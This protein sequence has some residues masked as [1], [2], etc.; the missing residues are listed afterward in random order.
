M[1]NTT[2]PSLSP[3][4]ARVLDRAFRHPRRS[5][6]THNGDALWELATAGLVNGDALSPEGIAAAELQAQQNQPAA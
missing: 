3:A 5:V 2:S 6:I 1:K 4:A